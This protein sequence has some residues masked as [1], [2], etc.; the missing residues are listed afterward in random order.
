MKRFPF[1]TLNKHKYL[2]F[3]FNSLLFAICL[4][5]FVSISYEDEVTLSMIITNTAIFWGG[6]FIVSFVLF[7]TARKEHEKKKKENP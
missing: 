1:Q 6:G 4:S 5:L 7:E 3:I 2:F